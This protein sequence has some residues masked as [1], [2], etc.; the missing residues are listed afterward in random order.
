MHF[1]TDYFSVSG[2][3]C[4]VGISRMSLIHKGA[5]EKIHVYVVHISTVIITL[6]MRKAKQKGL[7]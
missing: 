6:A 2:D 3:F 7:Y 4:V 5:E 1:E